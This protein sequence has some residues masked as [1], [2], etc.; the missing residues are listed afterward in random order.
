MP[1]KT[2]FTPSER[3][4]L[5]AFPEERQSL[6]QC[7]LFS[8][9]DLA[10]INQRR[11]KHN[12]L[13][14]AVQLCYLRYPGISLPP[15]G[16]PP[17]SLLRYVG[18]QLQISVNY[19]ANYAKRKTTR[20]EHLLELMS[21]LGLTPFTRAHFRQ[22]V[23]HL[24][25]LSV[26]TD[27]GRVLAIALMDYLRQCH[28]VIPTIDVIERICAEAVALGTRRIYRALTA[29]LSSGQKEQLDRLLLPKDQ[30]GQTFIHWLRQPHGVPNAKHILLH[31]ERI[32]YLQGLSLP[33]GIATSV[34][35][36]RLKKMARE[37][38]QM[39]PQHL[40]DFEPLRR[41]ATLVA[42]VLDTRAT[43]IDELIDMHDRVMAS[44]E[45]I[46]KRKHADQFQRSG[47]NINDQLKVLSWAGRV[48]QTAK[49]SGLDPFKAID[50][51]MG[52]DVFIGSVEHAEQL[53]QPEF[54]HL[55][56]LIDAY[57][58]LRR[59]TPALLETL[60][61]S[62][63]PARSTLLAAVNLLRRMNRT[64]AR[65]L[66]EDIPT[67]F[68]R[69]RWASLVFGPDG[70]NRRYYELCVFSELRHALRA[71]DIWVQHS[72]QFMD[73]EAYLLPQDTFQ[74][75]REDHAL[76]LSVDTD[77]QRF[78]E[79]K[80]A[81]LINA[82]KQVDQDAANNRLP[83]AL[84]T[85][86]GMRI[87]PLVN[88]VPDEAESLIRKVAALMP[89]VKITELLLEVDSWTGFTRHFTHLKGGQPAQDR[90]MLMTTLLADGINLGLTKMATSCPGTSYAKLSW[91]QAWH[92]RDETYSGA[93]AALTNAQHHHP[94]SR[95][96]GDGTTS[97]SDG[98]RFKAGGRGESKGHVNAKYGRD[99]GSMFYT[100][101]SDH[102]APFHTRI[103][104]SPARDATYVLDGLLNHESELNIEEHYTDTAGFT[105]HVF[106]LM[107]ILGF[108][109][110]PR[111]RDLSDKRIY[112]AGAKSDYPTLGGLIGEEI[113]FDY[114]ALHW[115]E[116]LRLA[117][118]IGKGT[119]TASLMLRKLGSYPR[120]NGLALALRE[121][122]RIERTLFTLEWMKDM[123]LRR[124]VQAGLNKGE[125]KNALSR[126]VFFNRLGELRDRSFE[127][128]RYRASG[129]NLI[130]A[131]IT[132]WNTEL[133]MRAVEILRKKGEKIDDS[134]LRHLSPLGWEHI[135]LTGDYIWPDI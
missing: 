47:K 92:I 127:N 17:A 57:T 66:P 118:S 41:H 3:Q 119:V 70:V 110:A 33:E 13:G 106:A 94:F 21:F 56:L 109:F 121:L 113:N 24:L 104:N 31:I 75:L 131:A 78:L 91:L 1:R 112:I 15:D 43:L 132:L 101:I 8:D 68:I 45:N 128:Q 76:G 61:L 107:P 114:V 11:G 16:Q 39:T 103:I 130:V 4:L 115:Q 108:K 99:P 90:I 27:T 98:Q 50:E 60:E 129:L 53:S 77:G 38:G 52:W 134:L 25:P 28:I 40:R 49:A 12:R 87:S 123:D 88:N 19:W 79:K 67:D 69:K 96:W 55:S 93:L 81:Q 6:I 42:V 71:G 74:R 29:R 18:E 48:L 64:Q 84:V 73:F 30:Q 26:Q 32:E 2:L 97:S 80:K 126:A 102:Y 124:R 7:Y 46:A 63:A 122:G 34:H 9:A 10:L 120:Q 85:S 23:H 72:R 51:A 89:K 14:F 100:H 5:L 37:G 117:A 86:S 133:T 35:Q 20:R 135:N 111:I 83:G 82:L 95:W 65:K 54:D 58:Q 125:A 44:K 62:A 105:D 59:Y 22:A 116:I 36:S